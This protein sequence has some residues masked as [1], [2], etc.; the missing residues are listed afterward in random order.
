MARAEEGPPSTLAARDGL[1]PSTPASGDPPADC[2]L[3]VAGAGLGA[4]SSRAGV[5]RLVAG[6]SRGGAGF[7]THA[8][9]PPMSTVTTAWTL[10]PRERCAT[11]VVYRLWSSSGRGCGCRE[12]RGA[13]LH[14]QRR[15]RWGRRDVRRRGTA[16]D[17]GRVLFL[18]RGV[19]RARE[20]CRAVSVQA[21]RGR[22]PRRNRVRGGAAAGGRR[23]RCGGPLIISPAIAPDRAVESG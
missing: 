6:A 21:V 19:R 7:D 18:R 22:L 23:G 20:D 16:V 14:H 5:A 9:T 8:T 10:A 4:L 3:R 2:A 13:R 11:A 15:V 1:R 17:A 12:K